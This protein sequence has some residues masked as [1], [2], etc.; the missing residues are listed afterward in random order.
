MSRRGLGNHR[1]AERSRLGD[2]G[3]VRPGVAYRQRG[4][5]DRDRASSFSAPEVWHEPL[6]RQFPTIIQQEP[7]E[8][9]WHPVT[10][11]EVRERLLQLPDW[12][13]SQVE[14]VQLSRMTRKRALFP[15]YGM[16]WGANIYLY[17]LEAG[18]VEH[19]LRPPNPQQ[20]IEAGMY[21]GTWTQTGSLWEL[22]WTYE[23]L[24]DFYLNNVLIHEVGHVLDQRNTT[25]R[26]RERYANWFAIE[27]GYRATGGQRRQRA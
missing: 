12:M 9:F 21:G 11:A 27:Y 7:G 4:T 5:I 18:L 13:T 6:D 23:G 24:R 20:R 3:K 19:Y 8:N 1:L 22:R 25:H 2:R 14:V 17:P 15:L 10:V 16:Q 26:D